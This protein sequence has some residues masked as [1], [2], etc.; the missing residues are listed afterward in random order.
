[1]TLL[2]TKDYAKAVDKMQTLIRHRIYAIAYLAKEPGGG[3]GRRK[4]IADDRQRI[5]LKT[6]AKEIAHHGEQEG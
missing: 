4:F 3:E 6:T 2:Y 5:R 1:M